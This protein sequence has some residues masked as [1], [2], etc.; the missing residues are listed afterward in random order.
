[1]N[2]FWCIPIWISGNAVLPNISKSLLIAAFFFL[3][4]IHPFRMLLWL[5]FRSWTRCRGRAVAISKR[6]ISNVAS[7]AIDFWPMPSATSSTNGVSNFKMKYCTTPTQPCT[8][9][10]FAAMLK[11]PTGSSPIWIGTKYPISTGCLQIFINGFGTFVSFL[12]LF[13][14]PGIH[15]DFSAIVR[16]VG[17]IHL[18]NLWTTFRPCF[19]VLE[20]LNSSVE[21]V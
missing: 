3:F 1:M 8:S 14:G 20:I 18:N 11:D 6:N 7:R 10:S 15:N 16:W 13:I 21:F 4:S 2:Q 19:T 9:S 5:L 12:F 17:L